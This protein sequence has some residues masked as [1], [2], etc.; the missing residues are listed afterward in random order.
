MKCK[1]IHNADGRATR[2]KACDV[3]LNHEGSMTRH[4]AIPRHKKLSR[5]GREKNNDLFAD[6]TGRACCANASFTASRN[7]RHELA[8]SGALCHSLFPLQSPF[9]QRHERQRGWRGRGRADRRPGPEAARR[10]SAPRSTSL[11]PT[12]SP[13]AV[14]RSGCPGSDFAGPRE[15]DADESLQQRSGASTMRVAGWCCYRRQP[16][17][18]QHLQCALRPCDSQKGAER[19][20][21]QPP[22]S[23]WRPRE[24]SNR[25]YDRMRRLGPTTNPPG[26]LLP[27]SPQ[28]VDT[29]LCREGVKM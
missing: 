14:S 9:L 8:T 15:V 2:R 11:F 23:K 6:S 4:E 21:K 20:H 28:H 24:G 13:R 19:I 29:S 3:S 16:G 26:L 1:E 10:H 5:R 7:G 12:S 22:E 27:M 17:N 18:L 25:V